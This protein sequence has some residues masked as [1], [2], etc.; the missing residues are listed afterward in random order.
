MKGNDRNSV[1]LFLFPFWTPQIPP[2]GISCLK[3]YISQYNY[4]TKI[5]DLNIE[6][7]IRN[8]YNEYFNI[9][10]NVVDNEI[11]GGGFYN[12]GHDLLQN[13]MMAFIKKKEPTPYISL[14]KKIVYNTFYIKVNDDVIIQLDA[15]L[16]KI[17]QFIEEF[18]TVEV[19]KYRPA[20]IGFSCFKGNLPTTVHACKIVKKKF[21][22]INTI[23]GGGVFAQGLVPHSPDFEYFLNDTKD[24]IDRIILGEGEAILLN[25]LEGKFS[26][27]QRVISS[28]LYNLSIEDAPLPD[29]SDLKI[30]IYP[31]LS[32]YTSRSCPYQCSFCT[33][34]VYWGKYRKKEVHK[35]IEGFE[36]LYVKY[37]YQLFLLGDSLLN[38]VINE[39]SEELIK[40]D[41]IIYWDGYLRI[42]KDSINPDKTLLWRKGGFYRARLGIE[43]G[44]ERVLN[45]MNKKINIEDIKSSIINLAL[46]GIK[47]RS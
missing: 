24:Y 30:D 10:K 21:K 19:E 1:L 25:I 40:K 38:P 35:I 28:E 4:R 37:N 31:S 14:I 9:I 42:S 6:E 33:E 47:R 36:S 45:L 43:S 11:D 2:L 44:S 16:K 41:S 13:H 8:N 26:D 22:G 3:S 5:Y 46:V 23:I 12:I 18:I 27:N 15:V 34:T 39:L 29:Y 7:S 20:N 17:F 32:F